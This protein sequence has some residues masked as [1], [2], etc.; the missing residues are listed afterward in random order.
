MI[1]TAGERGRLGSA[2]LGDEIGC[3]E[4]GVEGDAWCIVWSPGVEYE[5][6]RA[7][8]VN[9]MAWGRLSRHWSSW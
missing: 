9:L 3:G 5:G 4:A 8:S 7:R 2:G 6:C 1:A